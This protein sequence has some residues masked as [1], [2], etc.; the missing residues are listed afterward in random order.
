MI[1]SIGRRT[2]NVEE[3]ELAATS[4]VAIKDHAAGSIKRAGPKLFPELLELVVR[5]YK[6]E[7]NK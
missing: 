1:R 2:W 6:G 7:G 5:R 4:K 3:G